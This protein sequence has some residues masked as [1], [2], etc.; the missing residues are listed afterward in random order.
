MVSSCSASP[1]PLHVSPVAWRRASAL[2]LYPLPDLIVLA[3]DF[4]PPFAAAPPTAAAAAGVAAAGPVDTPGTE[5]HTRAFPKEY[6][7]VLS[8]VYVYYNDLFI[9][10]KD[11]FLSIVRGTC[12]TVYK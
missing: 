10:T 7:V 12:L 6:P 9:F 2:S 1:L 4:A 5:Q 8:P 3:G 11:M